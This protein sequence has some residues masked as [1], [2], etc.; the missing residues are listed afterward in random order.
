VIK[1]NSI[2]DSTG[3]NIGN[4]SDASGRYEKICFFI[5]TVLGFS[6]WFVMAVPFA[7]HRESYTWL[8]QI[9]TQTFSQQFSYGLSST[10]RPLAQVVTRLGF[11]FLDPGTFPTSAFRQALL[12]L[13]IYGLFV[14]AWWLIFSAAKQRRLFALIAFVTGGIF[15]SGYVQL[16]HIY[17][18]FYVPVILTLGALLYLHS[19]GTFEQREVWF[20]ICATV[21]VLWHPFATA[22]FM[23]FYFGFYVDTFHQRRRAQHVQAVSILIAGMVA[24]G[25]MV[26]V[27]PRAHMPLGTK[28]FGFLVSYRTNEVNLVASLAAFILTQMVV[29]S[30]RLTPRQKITGFLFV[31]AISAIFVFKSVPLLLLWICAAVIKLF[32]LRSWSLFFLALTAAVLPLGGG[33]GSPMYALF[34]III[35]T[36]VTALE[37]PQAERALTF[38]KPQYVLG[39]IIAVTTILL[40]VREGI[41]VPIVTKEATPLLSERERTYQLEDILAWLHN[42][43]YCGCDIAFAE[44]AGS[45]IESVN[46]VIAREHRP[47]AAIEDVRVFWTSDLQCQKAGHPASLSETAIVTFGGQQLA[48]SKP[49]FDLKGKYAG[50]AI[51]WVRNPH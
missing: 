13:S 17:G 9:H 41:R 21:L 31:S 29:F 1:K 11:L 24:I 50:D 26:V 8:S 39:T 42:S 12:Q 10:Y 46:N 30:M 14:Y 43:D 5:L 25:A 6:F 33:I 37:W 28:L 15:F 47:P 44:N 20:A 16:F 40:L 34:A 23:A 32:L 48:D 38:F 36:Y 2:K 4:P 3:S 27:F 51:V 22:L 18:M 35:A 7:S 49:I 45:P 19:S